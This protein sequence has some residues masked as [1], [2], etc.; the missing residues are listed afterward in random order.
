M[1]FTPL[2]RKGKIKMTCNCNCNCGTFKC[3]RF[4]HRAI[5]LT[6]GTTVALTTTNSD[7]INDKDPYKFCANARI[8]N[9]L[10]E[11][12]VPVT[13]EVNGVQVPVWNKYGEQI[14]SSAIPREAHGY[15][16]ETPTPHV[17]LNDTP[18]TVVCP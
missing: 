13:V 18:K 6:D 17:S 5:T 10:P 7:N 3:S 16:S 9:D 4:V 14:L 8:L 1:S 2:K 12:P 15:Y 11:T